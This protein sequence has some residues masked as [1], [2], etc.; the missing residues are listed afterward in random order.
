MCAVLFFYSIF[1][2]FD[3]TACKPVLSIIP[4]Q[5]PL[6]K[7]LCEENARIFFLF[8]FS[9]KHCQKRNNMEF[10]TCPQKKAKLGLRV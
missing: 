1:T 4:C 3:A 10:L 7:I 6:F 2:D 8:I 5:N 9:W